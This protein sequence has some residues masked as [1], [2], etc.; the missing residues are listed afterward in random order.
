MVAEE[1]DAGHVMRILGS[2]HAPGGCVWEKVRSAGILWWFACA[3]VERDDEFVAHPLHTYQPSKREWW[4]RDNLLLAKGTDPFQILREA[5]QLK[6]APDQVTVWRS[7][8]RAQ[9]VFVPRAPR[10]GACGVPE[11]LRPEDA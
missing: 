2:L 3:L 5:E 8:L 6:L 9:Y 11:S 4:Q 1:P 10:H 7:R